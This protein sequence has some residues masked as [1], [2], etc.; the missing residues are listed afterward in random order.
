MSY[1]KPLG[2][3]PTKVLLKYME[4]NKR[5]QLAARCPQI[6]AAEKLIPLK[7][8]SLTF[9]EMSTTVNDTTYQLG[10]SKEFPPGESMSHFD[11]SLT[12]TKFDIDE[13]GHPDYTTDDI[14]TPGDIDLRGH[15]R[16][17]HGDT[18]FPHDFWKIIMKSS[19][20]QQKELN[21]SPEELAKLEAEKAIAQSQLEPYNRR[22][23]NVPLSVPT[24][25]QLTIVGRVVEKVV[26]NKRL[27]Q[28]AKC[29]HTVFFGGRP[30]KVQVGKLALNS[31][32][33]VHRYPHD[34]KMEIKEL[35]CVPINFSMLDSLIDPSN[36]PSVKLTLSGFR[37]YRN[38]DQPAINQA[39]TLIIDNS[40]DLWPYFDDLRDLRASHVVLPY[41]S[42]IT[43]PVNLARHW[44]ENN[45]P[46]GTLYSFGFEKLEPAKKCLRDMRSTFPRARLIRDQGRSITYSLADGDTHVRVFY[47]RVLPI[48]G[49]SEWKVSYWFLHLKVVEAY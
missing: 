31:P 16:G 19:E 14:L 32:G 45:K 4:P 37:R 38:A 49:Q 3:D 42:H 34:F 26:Y 18:G 43:D 30:S 5:F 2:Y 8:E 28:A 15:R 17:E 48:P 23:N 7:I 40:D 9:G 24:F 10:V 35:S 29:L 1:S 12:G 47:E 25:I 13:F 33:Y 46:I 11:E 27:Y 6:R 44:L 41:D 36:Y 39:E 20:R 22:Q 21:L